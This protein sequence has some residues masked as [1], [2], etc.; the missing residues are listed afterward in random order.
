MGSSSHGKGVLQLLSV[1]L[2]EAVVDRGERK[3]EVVV[4][5]SEAGLFD[6][7][8][9]DQLGNVEGGDEGVQERED[10]VGSSVNE[11]SN[12]V[13]IL[14]S[15]S[16]MLLFHIIKLEGGDSNSQVKIFEI[17]LSLSLAIDNSTDKRIFIL[18]DKMDVKLNQA[19][20]LTVLDD[21][22]RGRV[23]VDPDGDGFVGS[24]FGEEAREVFLEVV[25]GQVQR[26]GSRNVRLSDGFV[27]VAFVVYE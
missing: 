13:Q 15:N 18:T 2:R 21:S 10:E 6:L 27:E 12:S 25:R 17:N 24:V 1:D 20:N 14:V 16:R 23:G 26:H 9:F 5:S 3:V 7:D 11:V 8:T 4:S 22:F 19:S